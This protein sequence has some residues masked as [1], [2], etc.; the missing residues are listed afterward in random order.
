MEITVNFLSGEET[1]ATLSQQVGSSGT[2]FWEH[3][4]LLCFF[5]YLLDVFLCHFLCG[6][7]VV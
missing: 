2:F 6:D 5:L 4:L 3:E 1:L 7:Y